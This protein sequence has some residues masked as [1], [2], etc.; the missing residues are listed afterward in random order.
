M[1]GG[2]GQDRGPQEA[3]YRR[4]MSQGSNGSGNKGGQAP[5]RGSQGPQNA[6]PA[7]ASTGPKNAGVPGANY[8][9]GGRGGGRWG[10]AIGV[11]II[12][13]RGSELI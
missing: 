12:L 3:G 7:N 2:G 11:V 13:T 10:E 1:G 4:Q 5:N 9:G 6:P 8:R